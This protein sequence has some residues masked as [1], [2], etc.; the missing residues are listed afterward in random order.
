MATN[1][2][3]TARPGCTASPVC[4]AWMRMFRSATLLNVTLLP[5]MAGSWTAICETWP[6]PQPLSRTAT[7]AMRPTNAARTVGA[8]RRRG[9]LIS[10]RFTQRLLLGRFH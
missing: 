6:A 1:T 5:L 4:A 2:R 7:T 3:S 9:R 10:K 8:G